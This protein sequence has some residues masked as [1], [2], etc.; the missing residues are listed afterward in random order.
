M[1][2]GAGGGGGGGGPLIVADGEVEAAGVEDVAEHDFAG[3][4]GGLAE[5]DFE[6]LHDAD[7]FVE[8]VLPA[9]EALTEGFLELF[10][11]GVFAV[12]EADES[13]DYVAVF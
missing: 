5:A 3:L 13:A 1:G 12:E 7:L 10:D 11:E 6:E 2:W 9:E 8:V 4:E